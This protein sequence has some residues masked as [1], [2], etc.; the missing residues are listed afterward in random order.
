VNLARP[1][2]ERGGLRQPRGGQRR[3]GGGNNRHRY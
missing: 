3:P 2:E 1:R